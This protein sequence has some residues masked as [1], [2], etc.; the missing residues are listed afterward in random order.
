MRK[1]TDIPFGDV[2]DSLEFELALNREVLDSKV[3]LPV[4]G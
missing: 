1:G 4:I 3:V 2:D